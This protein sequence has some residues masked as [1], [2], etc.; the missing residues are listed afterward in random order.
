MFAIFAHHITN[1]G[2]VSGI[3][4]EF[5]KSNIENKQST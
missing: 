2:L 4:K 5:S 1:K 3:F